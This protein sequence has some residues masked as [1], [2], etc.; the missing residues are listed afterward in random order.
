MEQTKVRRALP[1]WAWLFPVFLGLPVGAAIAF[2]KRENKG[3]LIEEIVGLLIA[4]SYIS[5]ERA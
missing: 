5:R 4:V 2:R 3:G 1:W